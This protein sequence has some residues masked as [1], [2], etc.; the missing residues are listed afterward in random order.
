VL[1]RLSYSVADVERVAAEVLNLLHGLLRHLTALVGPPGKCGLTWVR[2]CLKLMEMIMQTVA[3]GGEDLDVVL[4]QYLEGP[5]KGE[6][7]EKEKL[8][9]LL[10]I[11]NDPEGR[12]ELVDGIV[13][14]AWKYVQKHPNVW[15]HRYK[16]LD[17]LKHDI[18]YVETVLPCMVRQTDWMKALESRDGKRSALSRRRVSPKA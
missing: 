7:G 5:E 4:E 1:G 13:I 11:F 18:G 16:T 8:R 17:E 15:H 9:Q 12:H 10:K 2:D 3:D 6:Q 14:H